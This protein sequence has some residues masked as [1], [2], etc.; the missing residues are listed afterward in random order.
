MKLVVWV[1]SWYVGNLARR[2]LLTQACSTGK[3]RQLV[4]SCT[5]WVRVHYNYAHAHWAI[6]TGVISGVGD[7]VAQQGIE[8]CGWADH[9]WSRTLHFSSIGFFFV[10]YS[11][12]AIAQYRDGVGQPASSKCVSLIYLQGP[13][14]GRWFAQL[15][16]IVGTS[17]SMN[18]NNTKQNGSCD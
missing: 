15:D 3:V 11:T 18:G 12:L 5:T 7:V 16:R 1:W 14:L 9:D 4:S 17:Q 10:V 2:P 8:G 6:F 13:V